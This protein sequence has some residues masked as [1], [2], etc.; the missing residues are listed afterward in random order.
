M[1]CSE[2]QFHLG[3]ATGSARY[4]AAQRIPGQ[5]VKQRG[6]ADTRFATQ[7]QRLTLTGANCRDEPI[8]RVA[9]GVT[10][11]QVHPAT[12]HREVRRHLHRKWRQ[13]YRQ[14]GRTRSSCV[15]DSMPSL[16]NTLRR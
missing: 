16:A 14:S 4:S 7:H 1:Q 9:L 11:Y 6:L 3:L 2:G 12:P 8:E 5:I 13:P 10:V 15:R